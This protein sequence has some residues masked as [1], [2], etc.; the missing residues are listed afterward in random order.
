MPTAFLPLLGERFLEELYRSLITDPGGVVLV[1]ER[2]GAIA[3]F[4]AGSRSLRRSFRRF[5]RR[6]GPAAAGAA[7]PRLVR[8]SVLRRVRETASYPITTA[9]L[10]DAEL[11]AIA[12]APSARRNGVGR[13][14]IAELLSRLADLGAAKV[15]VV[16]GADNEAANAL[17]GSAGFELERTMQVHDGTLSN[18]W[19]IACRSPSPS[20]SRSS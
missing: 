12:V 16:V 8:P 10:P 20:L 6:R 14:L 2:D 9:G 19:T 17:Y 15:K 3:G 1:V 5:A 4:V 18:A 7:A 11:L 13:D